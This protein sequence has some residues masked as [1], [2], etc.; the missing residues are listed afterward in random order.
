VRSCVCVL[1]KPIV[2][3]IVTNIEPRVLMFANL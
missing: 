1:C 3:A 2:V